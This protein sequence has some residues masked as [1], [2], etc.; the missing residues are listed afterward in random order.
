[1]LITFE[2]PVRY[3]DSLGDDYKFHFFKDIKGDTYFSVDIHYKDPDKTP[4][5]F[6]HKVLG[7]SFAQP[8]NNGVIDWDAWSN[9]P[10]G[11]CPRSKA[12]SKEAIK[13][14]EKILRLRA[15]L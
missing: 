1:M 7:T 4:Q 13:F 3:T 5:I 11:L 15:F 6:G 8:F 12:M 10:G 2:H 9:V 14:A